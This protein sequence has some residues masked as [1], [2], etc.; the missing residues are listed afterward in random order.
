MP[1][2]TR[3]GTSAAALA[4]AR[5]RK[6]AADR[7]AHRIEDDVE[8]VALGLDLRAVELGYQTSD[9]RAISLEEPSSG[10]GAV[11]LDEFGVAPQVGEE[12]P[13][14]RSA[15]PISARRPRVL[16]VLAVHGRHSRGRSSQIQQ[17]P[18]VS[19]SA[20]PSR[21]RRVAPGYVTPR[22]ASVLSLERACVSDLCQ[23]RLTIA[24]HS[25]TPAESQTAQ[26]SRPD[27][28]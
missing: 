21:R 2:P 15:G 10:G 25:R 1:T 27:L 24:D 11:V 17:A 19:R 28:C 16:G 8:A 18:P 22:C 4:A 20:K 12:K 13:A 9:K 26:R 3:I 14:R 6:A 7:A 5:D 23:I